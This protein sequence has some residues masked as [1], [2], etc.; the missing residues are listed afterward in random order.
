[1]FKYT[2]NNLKKLEELFKEI[3][4]TVRYERGNF[5]SGYCI[6]EHK[7]IAVI[8]KF[9]DAEARINSLLEILSSIEVD[10]EQLQDK[11]AAFYKKILALSAQEEGEE[12]NKDVEEKETITENVPATEEETETP[13]KQE[14]EPA[15]QSPEEL[16]VETEKDVAE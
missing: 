11:T 13:E 3:G 6:V 7:K 2:K 16:A 4:Y 12:T 1:M 8:N 5:Q 15:E 9:F 14:G 10:P